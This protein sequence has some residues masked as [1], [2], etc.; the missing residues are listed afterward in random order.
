[1]NVHVHE[2]IRVVLRLVPQ[3]GAHCSGV[4]SVRHLVP[5]V[6][7]LFL[8]QAFDGFGSESGK[9]VSLTD[10]AGVV[11]EADIRRSILTPTIERGPSALLA[12]TQRSLVVGFTHCQEVGHSF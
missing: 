5:E 3:V 11:I 10:V 2:G 7:F 12:P 4:R 1:M 9:V 6:L 8:G